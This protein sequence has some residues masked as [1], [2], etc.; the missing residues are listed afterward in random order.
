MNFLSHLFFSQRTPLSMTGN[1]MGDFKREPD[2]Q[3]TLPEEILLGIENHRFV[4]KQ[5]DQ[6]A[7][8]KELRPLFSKERRRFAGVVTDI[9]FDYFLIKHWERFADVEFEVFV[10]QCYQGLSD[11][12]QW[13]PQRMLMVT[14]KMQEHDW[15]SSYG[16]LEGV[17]VTIDQV[18][19]RIRFENTMAGSIIEVEDN[20]A[21][22]ET[23]FLALFTHLKKAVEVAAIE[24]QN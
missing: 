4:D 14:S 13:M 5:T 18:S 9:A 2:L 19:K 1:L 7:G 8:V 3:I 17:A 23:V 24:V 11:C 10:Q 22:I 12:Q 6:F 21:E 15:L 16:T 20:Y